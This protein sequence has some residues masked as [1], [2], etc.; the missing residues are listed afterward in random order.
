MNALLIK[1]GF[2]VNAIVVESI[3]AIQNDSPDFFAS[4]DL[5]VDAS[6]TGGAWIGWSYDAN[7]D[8]QFAPP[9]SPG[10]DE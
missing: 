1:N 7:A 2:V 5:V 3:E 4:F 8:P 9:V 10:G 6:T